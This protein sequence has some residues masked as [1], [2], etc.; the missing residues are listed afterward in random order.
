MS[1]VKAGNDQWFIDSG[2]TKHMT[3][4][5]NIITDYKKYKEPSKIYLGD[6]RIIEAYGEGMSSLIA[7]MV[8]KP[9]H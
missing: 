7:M 9:L 4:Q 6:N 8:Q 3:F 2:A 5:R 1:N